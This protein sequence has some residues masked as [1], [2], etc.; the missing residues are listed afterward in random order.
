MEAAGE[1]GEKPVEP[2][3]ND[4]ENVPVPL[5]GP[6]WRASEFSAIVSADPLS[7]HLVDPLVY[8]RKKER[9]CEAS[10]ATGMLLIGEITQTMDIV[11]LKRATR[12]GRGSKGDFAEVGDLK[13]GCERSYRRLPHEWSGATARPQR[14]PASSCHHIRYHHIFQPLQIYHE[15]LD[16]IYTLISRL[17]YR[18]PSTSPLNK[19][20]K[21]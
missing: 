4:A 15:C 9:L 1:S 10:Q 12:A 19:R 16:V 20:S 2:P 3:V 13:S 14:E 18:N 5:P 6:W 8:E 11:T 7:P 17:T 21:R